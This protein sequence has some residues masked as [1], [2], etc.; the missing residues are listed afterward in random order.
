MRA[1]KDKFMHAGACFV[2]TI[3][4]AMAGLWN[5]LQRVIFVGGIIGGAKELYDA[6]HDGHDAEWADIAA[7]FTGAIIGEIFLFAALR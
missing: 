1:G 6:M 3:A 7:D 2:I 5:P 4:F